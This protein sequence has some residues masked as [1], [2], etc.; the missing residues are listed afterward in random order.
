M[1]LSIFSVLISGV[2]GHTVLFWTFP[3][4]HEF[5]F[6]YALYSVSMIQST[7][8]TYKLWKKLC[9]SGDGLS[10]P[11]SHQST[12]AN[13][14]PEWSRSGNWEGH[15]TWFMDYPGEPFWL[16]WSK[17][18][19]IISLFQDDVD[20]LSPSKFLVLDDDQHSKL[21]TFHTGSN[22][23]H[24]CPVYWELCDRMQSW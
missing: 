8:I 1:N 21:E 23:N 17:F 18:L 24:A 6:I 22:M 13:K 9:L 15:F 3:F 12:V 11:G 19:L 10:F 5:I 16:M 14:N 2:P 20:L 4:F 7:G